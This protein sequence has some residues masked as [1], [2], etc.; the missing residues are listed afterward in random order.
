MTRVDASLPEPL[1]ALLESAVSDGLFKG[2][3]DAARIATRD[4]FAIE[5]RRLTAV[6]A[7]VEARP[8]G[9]HEDALTLADVVRLSGRLPAEL[10]PEVR[11][12]YEIPHETNEE[13]PETDTR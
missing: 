4:Y 13:G 12:H 11:T 8:P 9:S 3:S 10:S 5:D 7:L 6:Q 2:P 1:V